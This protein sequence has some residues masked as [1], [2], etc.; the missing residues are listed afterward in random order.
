METLNWKTDRIARVT[1]EQFYALIDRNRERINNA[2]PVTVSGCSDLRNT[3]KFL[4]EAVDNE[5]WNEQYYFYL[6]DNESGELIGYVVIK[7]IELDI[8]ICELA[9][10]IDSDFE[11]KGIITK[12]VGNILDHC[13]GEMN[14][15]KVAISTLKLNTASQKVALKHGFVQEGILRQEFKSGEGVLED[16]VYFGLLK[17]EY[18][19]NEKN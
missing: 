12:A 16:I 7:N 2:F 1:P 4:K 15:N 3:A 10:F 5:I 8:S 18:R 9:Y 14:M 13:F 17:S 19:K 11:G 6:R